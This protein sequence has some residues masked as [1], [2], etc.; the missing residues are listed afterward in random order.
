MNSLLQA[1]DAVEEAQAVDLPAA[2]NSIHLAGR[3]DVEAKMG[4]E[5]AKVCSPKL[6]QLQMAEPEGKGIQQH[7]LKTLSVNT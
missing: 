5:I 3:A 4:S 7:A 1:D 6:K 2:Q